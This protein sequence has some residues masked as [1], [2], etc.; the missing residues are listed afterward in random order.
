MQGAQT[1]EQISKIKLRQYEVSPSPKKRQ[2]LNVIN[3]LNIL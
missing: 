3:V 1:R 2:L